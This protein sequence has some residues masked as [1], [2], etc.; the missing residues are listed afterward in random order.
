MSAL[1]LM[2]SVVRSFTL[3]HEVVAIRGAE[4]HRDIVTVVEAAHRHRVRIRADRVRDRVR[5]IPTPIVGATDQR[6][7]C[8]RLDRNRRRRRRHRRCPTDTHT[9]TDTITAS[10]RR[11][12]DRTRT[13]SRRRRS[14]APRLRRSR[15]RRPWTSCRSVFGCLCSKILRRLLPLTPRT[16]RISAKSTNV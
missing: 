15:R 3:R 7:E 12:T 6:A 13:P 1:R 2:S 8:R 9:T 11:I 16:R 4:V 5:P 14:M 10:N